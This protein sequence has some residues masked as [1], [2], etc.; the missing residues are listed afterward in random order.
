M[1]FIAV[2]YLDV[3]SMVVCV[4]QFIMF[5]G[6][7]GHIY[8]FSV[9]EPYLWFTF[10]WFTLRQRMFGNMPENTTL[11]MFILST[12]GFPYIGVYMAFFIQF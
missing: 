3:L 1:L 6:H 4:N 12:Q 9:Y 2:Q 10:F 5:S 11:C 8:D 7:Y